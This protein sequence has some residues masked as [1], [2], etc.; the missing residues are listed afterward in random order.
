MP[1]F[2]AMRDHRLRRF[3]T[4]RF[5][6]GSSIATPTLDPPETEKRP[7]S[8][9]IRGSFFGNGVVF[10]EHT[11]TGGIDIYGQGLR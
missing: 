11:G 7:S 3:Q 1:Q 5:N 6:R 8:S 4:S 10:N 2:R 9:F